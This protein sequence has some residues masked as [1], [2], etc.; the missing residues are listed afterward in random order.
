M[1]HPAALSSNK[2]TSAIQPSDKSSAIGAAQ[3]SKQFGAF[4]SDAISKINE[5]QIQ[6]DQLNQKFISGEL[7][8]VH[9]LVIASEKAALGLELTVQIRNKVI[10]AYQEVMRTQI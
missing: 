7:P 5:Q 1:I 2:I 4:L 6:V 9:N 8:D 10:E 3:V